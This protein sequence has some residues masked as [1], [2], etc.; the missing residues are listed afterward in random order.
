MKPQQAQDAAAFETPVIGF[1]ALPRERQPAR[2]LWPQI[3]ARIALTVRPQSAARWPYA[4]AAGL[5]A[6]L[7]TGVL[8]RGEPSAPQATAIAA[9][10]APAAARS[11]ESAAAGRETLPAVALPYSNLAHRA[12]TLTLSPRTLRLLRSESLDGA[13][14]L[15]AE[16]AGAL[17]ETGLTKTTFAGGGNG[18]GQRAILRANLKLVAQA[19]REVRRALLS[20]P[21]SASLQ[22]LLGVA[23]A[24]RAQLTQLLVHAQD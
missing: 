9:A 19:E 20:D 4:L 6:A 5:S 1:D 14:A 16:R 22:R 2:D 18:D 21:E 24:R 8:V 3:E 11:A 10:T 17:G 13:P 23:E 7:L 15:V 12:Q